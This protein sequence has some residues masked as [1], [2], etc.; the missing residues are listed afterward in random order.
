MGQGN[1]MGLSFSLEGHEGQ[2]CMSAGQTWGLCG[3][4]GSWTRWDPAREFVKVEHL[5]IQTY[6][7]S[8]SRGACSGDF[9]HSEQLLSILF[10]EVLSSTWI[11]VRKSTSPWWPRSAPY[12]QRPFKEIG[13]NK[14]V[15]D[16]SLDGTVQCLALLL[17][18]EFWG[19]KWFWAAFYLAGECS[20]VEW[21]LLQADNAACCSG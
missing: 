10:R 11:N 8:V 9:Y 2:P 12:P 14:S 15:V 6:T 4:G 19:A 3:L 16:F 17:R 13:W 20:L 18:P 1:G 5:F 21:S 7:G